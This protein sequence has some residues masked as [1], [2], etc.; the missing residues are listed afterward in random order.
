M[1]SVG[2][3]ASETHSIALRV[4][5]QPSKNT[6]NITVRVLAGLLTCDTAVGRHHYRMETWILDN[7]LP[8]DCV[9]MAEELVLVNIHTSTKN[10]CRKEQDYTVRTNAHSSFWVFTCFCQK[11]ET[12]SALML[13]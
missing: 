13:P 3:E 11:D 6:V 1:K 2:Y 4:T 12:N 5:G 9:C 8:M 10:L 7:I